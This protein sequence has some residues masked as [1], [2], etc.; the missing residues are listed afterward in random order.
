[1]DLINRFLKTEMIKQPNR[2]DI[3]IKDPH[4]N[5]MAKTRIAYFQ[6]RYYSF[7]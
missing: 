1:M 5:K 4:K 2:I 6:A 7:S 3:S